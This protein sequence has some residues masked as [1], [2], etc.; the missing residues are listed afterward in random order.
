M[1]TL[2]FDDQQ[3]LVPQ[4]WEDIKLGDY[5]KWFTAEPRNRI[6]QVQLVADICGIDSEILLDNPTQLFDTV[7]DIIGFAFNDYECPPSHTLHLDNDVLVIADTEDLTLAEWVDIE[8]VFESQSSNRLSDILSI[9]CRPI[10]EEYNSKVCDGRKEM[11]Q[12]LTMDKAM[13]LLA[14]FL[15][16]RERFQTVSN[17]YSAVEHQQNQCLCL[18]RDFVESGAGTKLLPIWQKIKF[19]FLMKFLK[20]QLSKFSDFFSTGST[21]Y[22]PKTNCEK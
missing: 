12:T 4:S 16:Q 8:S 10:G 18:I 22:K 11:F 3:I 15:Q 5:E 19:Y 21:K 17:L 7:Y 20:K 14:F 9:L 1:V 6:E 2:V 13:P